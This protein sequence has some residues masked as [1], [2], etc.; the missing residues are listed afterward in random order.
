MM[1]RRQPTNN[2]QKE[3]FGQKEWEIRSMKEDQC[4]GGKKR[5]G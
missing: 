5:G 4:G 2:P 1:G 3:P